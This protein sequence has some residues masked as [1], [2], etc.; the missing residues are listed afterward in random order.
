M[1]IT[2]R[3]GIYIL[4][5]P[6]FDGE[7]Q[8]S[9]KDFTL[10]LQFAGVVAVIYTL[11]GHRSNILLTNYDVSNMIV[12][13]DCSGVDAMPGK[14]LPRSLFSRFE[15]YRQAVALPLLPSSIAKA[16]AVALARFIVVPHSTFHVSYVPILQREQG[17][18]GYDGGL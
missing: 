17:Q 2:L 8:T 12:T 18:T 10:L 15:M 16:G 11:V 14:L 6:I 7:R 13:G 3:R 1:G 4:R 5:I 9:S